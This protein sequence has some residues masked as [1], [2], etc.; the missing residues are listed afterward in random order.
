MGEQRGDLGRAGES[1]HHRVGLVQVPRGVAEL[2]KPYVQVRPGREKL[3]SGELSVDASGRSPIEAEC[4][5]ALSHSR[6]HDDDPE[7]APQ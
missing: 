2:V 1:L 7:R 3:P 6:H 5:R 4:L